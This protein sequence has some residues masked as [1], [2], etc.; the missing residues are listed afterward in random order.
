MLRIHSNYFKVFVLTIIANLVNKRLK[1][2]FE[3]LNLPFSLRE[4][5]FYANANLVT[6]IGHSRP[7]CWLKFQTFNKVGIFFFEGWGFL[8]QPFKLPVNYLLSVHL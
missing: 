2:F 4:K 1:Y 7:L 8:D 5:G 6:A 3:N